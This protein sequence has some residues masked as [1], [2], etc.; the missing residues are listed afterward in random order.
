MNRIQERLVL[1]GKIVGLREAGLSTREISTQ[2]GISRSTVQRW[3]HR[4]EESGNLLDRERGKP[5]RKTTRE[6]DER[7]LQAAEDNPITNAVKIREELHIDVSNHTV[8]RRLHEGGL[9]HRTPAVKE[10]LSDRHRAM[11]L[12]FAQQYVDKD[13]DFWGRVIFT[14][15]K[16]FRST[17]HGRL[18]CWRRNDTR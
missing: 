15:E 4:W 9:H 11:R 1:R 5:P 14:D 16:T 6:Q 7:I 2:L 10:V 12:H 17:S 3:I 8:R 18:H 13:L